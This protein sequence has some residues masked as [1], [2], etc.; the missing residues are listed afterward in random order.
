MPVATASPISGASAAFV[1]ASPSGVARPPFK[2]SDEDDQFL[3]EVQQ[4][5]F[6]WMFDACN[7]E[8]GL[9]RDRSSRE[10][11]SVAAV[12]FMLAGLPVGV[13]RGWISR[14]QGEQRAIVTLR[15][16]ASSPRKGGLF[17]HF[18]D[19]R[20]AQIPAEAPEDVVSTIDSALLIAGMIVAGSYFGGEAGQRADAFIAEANWAFFTDPAAEKE[21]WRGFVSLGWQPERLS[22]PKGNGSLLPYFWIDSGDEQR[23]V[24]FLAV[25]TP[26]AE[27]SIDPTFYYRMRRQIGSHPAS[28]EFSYIPWSGALFT[29]FFAH[30]FINYA[31]IGPDEPKR[32]GVDRRASIDWWE[33]SRRA[34]LMHRARASENVAVYPILAEHAWG[35]TASD[36]AK[37]YQVPGLYPSPERFADEKPDWDYESSD[38]AMKQDLGDGT[39]APYGA[40]CAI[41]F[42]PQASIAAMRRFRSLTRADGS[43]LAW[44]S[45]RPAQFGSPRAGEGYGFVDA[46]HVGTGWAADDCLGID[47]GPLVLSIENARSGLIWRLFHAHPVVKSGLKR[48][49][50]D[51]ETIER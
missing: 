33:N 20:T 5:A 37:G 46:F 27:H 24:T 7:P 43:P 45:P 32:L 22:E 9:T 6:W 29:N 35:L 30:C 25:A 36:Y 47:Q 10:F 8:T 23:L 34:V 4:A 18:L 48:L 40:G 38:R 49:S 31:A 3:D 13:E 1:I 2:F 12:G 15:A 21:H 39:I 16:L 41:M 26:K 11:S 14:S 44:R 51:R 28:G 19:G 50:L 42:D 17:Y